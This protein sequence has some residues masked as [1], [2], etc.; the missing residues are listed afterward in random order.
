MVNECK[1]SMSD[2]YMLTQLEYGNILHFGAGTNFEIARD[3]L[4]DKIFK[5]PAKYVGSDCDEKVVEAEL[6][7]QSVLHSFCSCKQ[8]SITS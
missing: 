2:L 1:Q 3:F 8:Y 7:S 5:N 4:A 6:F